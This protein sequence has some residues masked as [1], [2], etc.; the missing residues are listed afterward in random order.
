MN[1]PKI[2]QP[3]TR[4]PAA[5]LKASRSFNHH[6]LGKRSRAPIR[7]GYFLESRYLVPLNI[8]Q[9]TLA[10]ALGISRRR[11][12][13]LIR[14]HRSITPDTAI[15]LGLYFGT[16]ASFWMEMQLAWDM[17]QAW[18]SFRSIKSF[19]VARS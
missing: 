11:V 6:E 18:R 15:R 5:A 10:R 13:E 14:G 2:K 17:H 4:K 19:P 16:D 8:N 9:Q 3:G 7:P 1:L 12:N